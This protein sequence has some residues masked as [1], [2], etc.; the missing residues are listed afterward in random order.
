MSLEGYFTQTLKKNETVLSIVRKHWITYVWPIIIAL[1]IGGLLLGFFDFFFSALWG[2]I[3]WFSMVTLTIVFLLYY[4][5]IHYFD[6]FIVTDMRIIDIDQ[7]G[8]FKRTVSETTFDTVQ[9]VTYS[10]V[11]IIAT[12][13]DYG[14]VSVQTA[15]SEPRLELDHVHKPR[16]VQ[17]L[18]MEARELYKTRHASEMSATELIELISKVGAGEDNTSVEE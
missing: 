11:G 10:I 6:S 7:K 16:Q 18:I 9:D 8:L 2:L 12:S 13:L 14:T 15:G 5:V 4:W 1:L 17:E 3:I